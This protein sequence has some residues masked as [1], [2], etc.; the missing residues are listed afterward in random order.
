[1]PITTFSSR[2]FNQAASRAGKAAQKGPVF[3]T[4]RGRLHLVLLS[5]TEYQKLTGKRESIGDMLADSAAAEIDFEPPRLGRIAQS[6][7]LQ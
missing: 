3:V 6:V 7:D 1:M 5:A 4:N 2:E